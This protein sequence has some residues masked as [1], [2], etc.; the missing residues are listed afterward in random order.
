MAV[1]IVMVFAIMFTM[2]IVMEQPP[3][4]NVDQ[5]STKGV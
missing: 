2:L 5:M 1:L 3:R 4:R